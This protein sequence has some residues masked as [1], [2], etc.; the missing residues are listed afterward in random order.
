MAYNNDCIRTNIVT[1]VP[2]RVLDSDDMPIT[3]EQAKAWLKMEGIDDDDL[4]INDLISEAVEW[5]QEYC[6]ISVMPQTVT[7]YIQVKNS[8][9][10]PYGPVLSVL[11][12]DG[13]ELYGSNI[14]DMPNGFVSISKPGKYP[15]VYKAGYDPVPAGIIGV[16]KAYIAYAYEHRGDDLEEVTEKISPV[17][18]QKA[19]PYVRNVGF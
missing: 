13:L 18:I 9:E 10:L 17:A 1:G 3:L 12:V 16:I 7:A 19:L 8:L 4:I 11:T 2:S 14:L 15:V 5:V 6:G